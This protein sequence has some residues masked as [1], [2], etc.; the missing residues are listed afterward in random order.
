[1]GT[2]QDTDGKGYLLIHHGIIYELSADYKSAKRIASSQKEGGESP[3]I[4]KS[5]G[6]YFW[7]SSQLTSWE[8]NDNMYMTS[9]SI[10]GPWKMR[11]TFAPEGTLT[12]NSQCTFV[13][14]IKNE[15]DTLFMYMGDRW[16]F[17]LQGSAATYVWQPIKLKGDSMSIPTYLESW[18][19][20]FQKLKVS[21]VEIKKK[22]VKSKCVIE[23]GD[24]KTSDG[25]F[26]SK[27][28]GAVILCSFN[29]TQV[30]I[31]AISNNTSGYGRVIIRN[32]KNEEIIN[33]LVDFYSKYEYSSQKFLSPVMKKDHYTMRIEVLGVHAKWSDKRKSDYGSTADFV[34]IEDLYTN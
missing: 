26:V 9:K 6:V 27:E 8:R 33:T 10:E 5:N 3:T 21:D 12:W 17:P 2:F 16:S 19:V 31:K 25:K 34:I 23:R 20:D 24:W 29:G 13:L 14:P 30:G 1:M 28:K 22:S 7:L 15:K 32:S 18:K 4:F 11:G